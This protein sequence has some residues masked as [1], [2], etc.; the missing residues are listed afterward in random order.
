MTG[1]SMSMFAPL[2]TARVAIS[3]P[4]ITCAILRQEGKRKKILGRVGS[5]ERRQNLL[6]SGWD[7]PAK[8]HIIVPGET[9]QPLSL[10]FNSLKSVIEALFNCDN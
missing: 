10:A 4:A 6:V 9:R 2:S 5:S 1:V 8:W 7:G 3:R